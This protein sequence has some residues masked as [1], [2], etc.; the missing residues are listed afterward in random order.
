MTPLVALLTLATINSSSSTSITIIMIFMSAIYF[1]A[2][3]I[4]LMC[5]SREQLIVIEGERGET[6]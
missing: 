3:I 6:E 1:I 4:K 2:V 5:R